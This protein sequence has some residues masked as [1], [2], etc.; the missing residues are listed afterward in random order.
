MEINCNPDEY[1]NVVQDGGDVVLTFTGPDGNPVDPP[2]EF[3]R[4]VI[5]YSVE[6]PFEIGE[7]REFPGP[8]F[9]KRTE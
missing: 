1:K 4:M 8:A 5:R 9:V 3:K 2:E 7:V 6:F